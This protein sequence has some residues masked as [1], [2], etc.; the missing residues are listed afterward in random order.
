M[1]SHQRGFIPLVAIILLG[2]TAV[3]GGTIATVSIHKSVSEPVSGSVSD[4]TRPTSTPASAPVSPRVESLAKSTQDTPAQPKTKPVE[5]NKTEAQPLPTFSATSVSICKELSSLQSETAARSLLQ[6]MQI[7]CETYTKGGYDEERIVSAERTLK[8]KWNLWRKT[9][10]ENRVRAFE[11][12]KEE[13]NQTTPN[14]V[15]QKETYNESGIYP[16]IISFSDNYGNLFKESNYNGYQGPYINKKKV[17]LKVGDTIKATVEAKDPKGRALEY[18]WNSNSQ[19]FNKAH[20]LDKAGYQYSSSNSVEY[21]ITD[22][23]L[24]SA[25][26]T[27]RLVYQVRVARTDY[28]RFGGGQYDDAGFIDYSLQQ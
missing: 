26:E 16:I 14:K 9:A 24:K 15:I 6:D 2:I 28:Y 3:V 10:V 21:K 11:Q 4:T 17:T 1:K 19:V 5:Q 27:F 8:E 18:N 22:E 25:G 12:Q 13:K 23:D 7:I 20:G